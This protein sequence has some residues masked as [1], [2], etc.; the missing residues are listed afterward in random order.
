MDAKD[1]KMPE[2]KREG[3]AAM[4]R[5]LREYVTSLHLSQDAV[6]ELLVKWND[7]QHNKAEFAIQYLEWL[8]RNGSA[9]HES[10]QPTQEACLQLAA[11]IASDFDTRKDW[12]EIH[13]RL[14][15]MLNQWPRDL[16]LQLLDPR[17][18][19][20][21]GMDFI[22]EWLHEPQLSGYALW[23]WQSHFSEIHVDTSFHWLRQSLY[24][25]V[26]GEP[27]I[28]LVGHRVRAAVQSGQAGT[29]FDLV[30]KQSGEHNVAILPALRDSHPERLLDHLTAALDVA[31][32]LDTARMRHTPPFGYS[33]LGRP[34]IEDSSQTENLPHVM[35]ELVPFLLVEL[36]DTLAALHEREDKSSWRKALD[37]LNF[38]RWFAMHR[39]VM[40]SLGESKGAE[41][42]DLLAKWL[43]HWVESFTARR[44]RADSAE[45]PSAASEYQHELWVL[46]RRRSEDLVKLRDDSWK[47]ISTTLMQLEDY[48]DYLFERM[49]RE[50][51]VER[52]K[53]VGRQMHTWLWA[54]EAA[55]DHPELERR[56]GKL[57]DYRAAPERYGR[58]RESD[59]FAGWTS[60]V[61]RVQYKSGISAK[62][63]ALRIE[64]LGLDG[65][66]D[67]LLKAP[68]GTRYDF[69]DEGGIIEHDYREMLR[70]FSRDH[71]EL[72]ADLL[73][74][75][76]AAELATE[77]LASLF[78][79]LYD[80]AKQLPLPTEKPD[81]VA[82]EPDG[83]DTDATARSRLGRIIGA[84]RQALRVRLQLA[85]RPKD[86]QQLNGVMMALTR[87]AG[88]VPLD[89]RGN[90]FLNLIEKALEPALF[91][92]EYRLDEPPRPPG[93]ST[94]GIGLSRP[95]FERAVSFAFHD[96]SEPLEVLLAYTS[97]LHN[98][99]RKVEKDDQTEARNSLLGNCLA[100]LAR[101]VGQG[102]E[103]PRLLNYAAFTGVNLYHLMV[104]AHEHMEDKPDLQ[105][106]LLDV[107]TLA[108][109]PPDDDSNAYC[110][111][112]RYGFLMRG[113]AHSAFLE[114]LLC[115]YNQGLNQ[116]DHFA[117]YDKFA[118]GLGS[119]F[120]RLWINRSV[121]AHD[122]DSQTAII[123][124]L[125]RLLTQEGEAA[126][127]VKYRMLAQGRA[128]SRIDTAADW[129]KY[130]GDL[131]SLIE[132]VST[133]I[134]AAEARHLRLALLGWVQTVPNEMS[135]T[136]IEGKEQQSPDAILGSAVDAVTVD[137]FPTHMLGNLIDALV[138]RGLAKGDDLPVA[139]QLVCS[140]LSKIAD[141]HKENDEQI[142]LPWW[143]MQN[144][145]KL[146][147]H[148]RSSDVDDE[149]AE[150]SDQ[151]ERILKG[152]G[153]QRAS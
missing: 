49:D 140:A 58:N 11:S 84:C 48:F 119:A 31:L 64:S 62:E 145:W 153:L 25:V 114:P 136:G 83:G 36:R 104:L 108:S 28:W 110:R 103:H 144:A 39:L 59:T 116:V 14:W 99:S 26:E 3:K 40:H 12:V 143:N 85:D 107:L 74:H 52:E 60:G 35:E 50:E 137:D 76:R 6:G 41:G 90:D 129:H 27:G 118:D 128:V 97:R 133:E 72:A 96:A 70:E 150:L 80:A 73:G 81:D 66:L 146:V 34:S 135:L 101:E 8:G 141:I 22:A 53:F 7:L 122:E 44:Q 142:R 68:P 111:F 16:A 67:F 117:E 138:E 9:L 47:L 56:K 89:D 65:S 106:A 149:L 98:V 29:L 152:L 113:H 148:V 126:S 147:D 121:L 61:G 15:W 33:E 130:L 109:S 127:K 1:T 10:D 125:K 45:K 55:L 78:Y 63:F 77:Y 13:G 87:L 42:V 120:L 124:L 17:R 92:L 54:V 71:L 20:H 91:E 2:Q 21:D 95:E 100:C 102:P 94:V 19:G 5:A 4:R 131:Y 93:Q 75:A 18:E 105:N 46:L 88:R 151:I 139:S 32:Y 23:L 123:G 24:P 132:E 38:G 57:V 37:R 79:G 86:Q 82:A 43:P 30:E 51:Q 112:L 69:P 134:G 115:L